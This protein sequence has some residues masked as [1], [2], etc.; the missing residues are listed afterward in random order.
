MFLYLCQQLVGSWQEVNPQFKEGCLKFDR[1]DSW[2]RDFRVESGVK[3]KTV[4]LRSLHEDETFTVQYFSA[5]HDRRSAYTEN[6]DRI[7]HIIHPKN[8]KCLNH[9][10]FD[11]RDWL[12]QKFICSL[13]MGLVD[14]TVRRRK[15]KNISIMKARP[16]GLRP[17]WS[18]IRKLAAWISWDQQMLNK[19]SIFLATFM[20]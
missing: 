3:R 1:S 12:D 8:I 4:A 2:K 13:F 14:A 11:V 7:C 17:C 10:P 9:A 20:K 19:W 15:G 5:R 16:E 18:L 6:T